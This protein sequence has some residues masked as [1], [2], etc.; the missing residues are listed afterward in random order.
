[1]TA[2]SQNGRVDHGHLNEDWITKYQS[3]TLAMD[4][5]QAGGRHLTGC[6]TCRRALLA[7]TGTLR[8]PE[9]LTV[10]PEALHLSYE[11]I[12][13]YIDGQ[14]A[15]ADKERVE[16]HTYICESCSREIENLKT[17]DAQLAAP[18]PEVV[19]AVPKLSLWERMIQAFRVPGAMPKFGLAFGA[20][21][22]GVVLLF[23]ATRGGIWS[24]DLQQ[25]VLDH[26]EGLHLGG[27]V[28]VLGGVFYIVYRMWRQ[29]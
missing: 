7:R 23:P 4:E 13:A 11:Q 18:A 1:M 2:G 20:I 9:E 22:A 14:L 3:K 17:L 27:Y 5:L 25:V 16:A 21:V 8:L 28:L 6:G 19:P 15:G 26:R 24:P 29:R 10:M 12:S